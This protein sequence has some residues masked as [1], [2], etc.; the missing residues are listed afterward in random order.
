MIM[1][2]LLLPEG[3]WR[4]GK[5]YSSSLQMALFIEHIAQYLESSGHVIIPF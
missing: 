5:G 3:R 1:V 2:F 4:A